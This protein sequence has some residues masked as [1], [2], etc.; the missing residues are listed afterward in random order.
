MFVEVKY[1]N[2][3]RIMEFNNNQFIT[4]ND[5]TEKVRHTYEECSSTLLNE[6]GRELNPQEIVED[7]R[8]YIVRR[9]PR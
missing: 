4:V 8:V 3:Y 1:G 9:R 6:H 7:A 5:I 2:E